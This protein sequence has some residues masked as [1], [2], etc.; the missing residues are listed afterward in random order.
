MSDTLRILDVVEDTVVD[1]PG[2][3]T[4]IYSAGCPHHC[5]GCHNPESWTDTNGKEVTIDELMA[6]I[7]ADSLGN[8]TFS[9]GD[10]LYQPESFAKL[11]YRIKE[12][13]GKNIWCYTGYLFEYVVGN[14]RLSLIL[15]YIDVL[16]DGRFLEEERDTTL[17]F[18]GSRN[19]RLIDVQASLKR[20]KT[21]LFRY[22][23]YSIC[24][25]LEKA[26][27]YSV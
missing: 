9:G 2:L 20:Q 22:D 24:E 18:R 3:R 14:P 8:I 15:P 17:P 1:G 11:A 6:V 19:Q 26:D 10:P 16:V 5:P 12:E 25:L 13:T 21:V 27:G 4:A 23:P 7:R